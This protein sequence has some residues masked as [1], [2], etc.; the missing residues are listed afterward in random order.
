MTALREEKAAYTGR[1]PAAGRP[2]ERKK[3]AARY[4]LLMG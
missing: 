2:E 4:G 1:G 3:I